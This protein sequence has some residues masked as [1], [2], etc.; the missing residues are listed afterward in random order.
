MADFLQCTFV[1]Q[2]I[3]PWSEVFIQDLGD[4]GFESFQWE[5]EKLLAYIDQESMKVQGLDE[6]IRSYRGRMD[7][8]MSSAVVEKQNWNVEWES[9][10]HP[11]RLDDRVLVRAHFH[12]S[13][14]EVEHEIVITPKM[15]FG[16]G[17]HA[18]TKM[19]MTGMFDIGFKAMSVLDVG[20]GTGVLAILAEKMGSTEV[21]AFDTDDWA[22][23]NAR[24]N[25]GINHCQYVSVEKAEIGHVE[26][27]MYNV[28]LANINFNVIVK[29]MSLYNEF[30]SPGGDM[31]L[32]GFLVAD[33]DELMREAKALGL[34]EK[35]RMSMGEWACLHLT[36]ALR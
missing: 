5:G 2:P 21:L 25:A 1:L 27:K 11:V 8:Q 31:L 9:N 13:A 16:T 12:E 33:A 24:E 32:S 20:T 19:M 14:S 30:L 23:E 6:V 10:Y 7:I 26:R 36:K 17:H 34:T 3:Q 29:D 35:N 22:V 15:S 28:I 18:T 4:L